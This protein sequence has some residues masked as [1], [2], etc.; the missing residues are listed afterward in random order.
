MSEVKIDLNN[1]P[2]DR[3]SLIELRERADLALKL[4]INDFSLFCKIVAVTATSLIFLSLL[5]KVQMNVNAPENIGLE[6]SILF[7]SIGALGFS[8][9]T[10]EH[11][12]QA[13]KEI[14]YFLM[15]IIFTLSV[16]SFFILLPY[17]H[18]LL[19]ALMGTCFIIASLSWL[20]KR[21]CRHEHAFD[22]VDKL[23]EAYPGHESEVKKYL[24]NDTVSA[25]MLKLNRKLLEIELKEIDRFFRAETDKKE[26]EK[27]E[28]EVYPNL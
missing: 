19:K 15:F 28:K 8:A 27:L 13:E 5:I 2:L 4:I 12:S 25:Y 11:Q 7:L 26:K 1:E 17:F 24:S 23:K 10:D 20:S 21:R 14:F 22:V 16:I 9:S 6:L 18:P 3:I